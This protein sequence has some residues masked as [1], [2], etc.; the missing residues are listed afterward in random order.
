[1]PLEV[2]I[3]FATSSRTFLDAVTERR[4]TGRFVPQHCTA[5]FLVDLTVQAEVAERVAAS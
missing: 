3:Y 4:A 2:T 5:Q 1:M